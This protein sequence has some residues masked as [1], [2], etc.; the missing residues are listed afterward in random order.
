MPSSN[1]VSIRIRRNIREALEREKLRGESVS[2]T[3]RRLLQ[4]HGTVI[5]PDENSQVAVRLPQRG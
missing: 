1:S 4:R 2:D 3:I 5:Q